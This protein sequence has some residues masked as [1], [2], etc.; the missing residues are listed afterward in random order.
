M[1]NFNPYTILFTIIDLLI[2][3]LF[4]RHFLFNKVTTILDNR[5]K[6]VEAEQANAKQERAQ[7][8]ELRVKYEEQLDQA[9]QDGAD[10]VAKSKAQAQR[11]YQAIL[12]AA[13][14]DAEHLKETTRAQ[15]ETE[16]ENMVRGAQKEVAQLALLAAARVTQKKLDSQDDLALVDSFLAE[17]GDKT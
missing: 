13:H 10:L 5:A 14:A 8:E 16:R 1:L 6:A 9:R 3:W 4:L 7:A 15:L 11:E 12:D 2:L 17:V